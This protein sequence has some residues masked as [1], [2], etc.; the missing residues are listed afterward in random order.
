VIGFNRWRGV[1]ADPIEAALAGT[2]AEV[3]LR[4]ELVSRCS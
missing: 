3:F 4:V 2:Y 1:F